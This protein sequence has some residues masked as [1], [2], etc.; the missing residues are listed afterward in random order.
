MDLKIENSLIAIYRAIN[1]KRN[2]L[3]HQTGQ[4]NSSADEYVKA[5]KYNLKAFG[6]LIIGK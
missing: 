3:V 5:I 1:C 4:V 2:N 6:E